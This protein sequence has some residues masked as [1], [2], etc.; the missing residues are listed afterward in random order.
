MSP[1]EFVTRPTA[2]AGIRFGDVYPWDIQDACEFLSA[3]H[4]KHVIHRPQLP[5]LSLLRPP[6]LGEPDAVRSAPGETL[7]LVRTAKDFHAPARGTHLPCW[8][9]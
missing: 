5:I 9:T 2:E 6:Y 1:K 4:P 7:C 8:S 3:R